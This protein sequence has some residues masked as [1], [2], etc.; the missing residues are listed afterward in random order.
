MSNTDII[1]SVVREHEPDLTINATAYTNVDKAELEPELAMAI[2][3]TGPGILA[4]ETKRLGSVLIH[5]STDYVFDGMKGIP[6]TEEDQPTPLS[7]YGETKLAGEKAVEAIGGAYLIFRTSWVY[8]L[9]RPCFVTKVLKWSREKKTLRIVNDQI[10][11]PTWAR[12]LAENTTQLLA[13]EK[14][15]LSEYF[16][17]HSGLY[18]L[19][20]NGECSRYE[21][22]QAILELDKNKEENLVKEI[23][24]AKSQ[25][26][27]TLAKRPT[28]STLSCV[29]FEKEFGFSLP[30]WLPVLGLAMDN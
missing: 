11:T 16:Y 18:H 30:H 5:Y 20:S 6:Y 25:D 1:K 24:T 22:A 10:S 27:K 8:S 12:I 3:G 19:S 9:R 26:F 4:E 14:N 7:I 13:M 21:W 23:L 15:H 29:K 28:R 17:N 2:N